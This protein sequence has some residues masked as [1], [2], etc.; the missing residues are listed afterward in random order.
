MKFRKI[1]RFIEP[2][3]KRPENQITSLMHAPPSGALAALIDPP[4][5]SATCLAKL[6]SKSFSHIAEFPFAV[7]H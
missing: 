6:R 2:D 5:D 3:T 7:I 1:Q 4:C